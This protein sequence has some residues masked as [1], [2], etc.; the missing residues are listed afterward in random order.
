MIEEDES[1]KN[2]ESGIVIILG[3][4]IFPLCDSSHYAAVGLPLCLVDGVVSPK[5]NPSEYFLT[6]GGASAGAA[7]LFDRPLFAEQAG[8]APT[9]VQ[10]DIEC[11]EAVVRRIEANRLRLLKLGC[12]ER[13]PMHPNRK[14][15]ARRWTSTRDECPGCSL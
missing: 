5:R 6:I 11:T 13:G 1:K 8:I 3:L 10:R 14:T 9:T 4:K 7:L 12:A 2:S 15:P